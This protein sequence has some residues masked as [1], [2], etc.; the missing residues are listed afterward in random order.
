MNPQAPRIVAIG[1]LTADLVIEVPRL[2]I[3]ADDFQVTE[4]I[5]LEAGGSANLLIQLSHLGASACALGAVGTDLWGERVLQILK[6]EGI[7]VALISR[8]GTT[9]V[10]LVL[11]DTAGNH[12][13][14]G[15]FGR[16]EPL[17]LGRK[18]KESVAGADALFASGYSLREGRLRN[19][20]LDAL[21]YAGQMGI[22]RFF[23]PGP[24]F[25]ELDGDV[26]QAAL[27]GSDVL[28][29]TEEELR[30]L[31]PQG[32]EPLLRS[33]STDGFTPKSGESKRGKPRRAPHTVVVKRGASGCRVFRGRETTRAIP[34]HAVA[35]RDT[36][37]AGDC[38]DAGYL[39]AYLKGWSVEKCAHLANCAGAAAVRKLGGGRNVPTLEELRRLIAETDSE[40]D[41]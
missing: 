13:F 7:Q 18:E 19:L 39:L 24:V 28:L 37:A 21:A 4:T 15:S 35:A 25:H 30:D 26:I 38:F 27:A 31:S 10:A 22:P 9:T 23:D 29:L 5:Q 32:A 41:I 33:D 12:S 40:I 14:V 8:Q 11:V 20:T 17:K 36:T 2:P 16:G 1:D 6:E 34:G 3:S